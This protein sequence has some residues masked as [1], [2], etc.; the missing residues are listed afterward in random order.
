MANAA[1]A[2]TE[3]GRTSRVNA[4]KGDAPSM[5]ADSKMSLGSWEM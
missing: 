2:G 1:S 3:R 4:V 5:N